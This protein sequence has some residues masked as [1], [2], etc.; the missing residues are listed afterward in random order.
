MSILNVVKYFENLPP[1]RIDQA[2]EVY[3]Y[4]KPCCVESHLAHLLQ[5]HRVRMAGVDALARQFYGNRAHLILMLRE[6]G[7]GYHPFGPDP[8]PTP[9]AEVFQQ[10]AEIETLPSLVGADLTE[11]DLYMADLHK[12]DLTQANLT[13]AILS[14]ADLSGATLTWADLTGATLIQ[15]NLS[16]ANLTEANLSETNLTEATLIQANLRKANLDEANLRDANLTEANLTGALLL[17]VDLSATDLNG[18][19]GWG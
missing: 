2:N 19:I 4:E 15:T 16:E 3:T 17:G 12:T 14:Y 13:E 11:A 7:A 5:A 10:L 8:W 18:A 9:P 6:C 1:D